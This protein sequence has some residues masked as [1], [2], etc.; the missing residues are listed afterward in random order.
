MRQLI[1]QSLALAPEPPEWIEPSQLA[2]EKLAGMSWCY[3]LLRPSTESAMP[4]TDCL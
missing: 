2:A 3:H 4:V 1:E